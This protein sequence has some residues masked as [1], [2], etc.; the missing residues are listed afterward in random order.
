MRLDRLFHGRLYYGWIVAGVTFLSLLAAAGVRSMP[1]VLIVPLERDFGWTRATVSAA[2]SINLLLY[3]F[4]GPFAAALMDR[5]GVRRTMVLALA[6]LATGVGMTTVMRASWQLDVLWGVVVGIGTGAMAMTLG[7]YVATRWFAE[8]R[9]LVMGMLTASSATGQLIFLPLLASLVVLH[10][11][12][13]ATST[14]AVVALAMIPVV[15][16]FMRNDP[17]DIGLRP[18]GAT[19][20]ADADPSRSIRPPSS[21]PAAPEDLPASVQAAAEAER[22]VKPPNPAVAAVRALSDG[23]RV[24]DFW[25]LAG[26][27]FV[28][29]ASTQGLIGTHL[30]PASMEHGIPEVTAAGML[31]TI[32]VFDLVGTVCSG[33][34]TDRWDSRYLLC[35]YYALRGLSLLFLPYALGTSFAGMAAFAVFYGL[36]WVATVPPT[37]RLTADIFGRQRV[38]I[39]FGWI[40]ASHQVGSAIAAFGAGAARTSF[41]T[42]QGAFMAAGLLCLIASGL[43]MR[44]SPASRGLTPPLRPAEAGAA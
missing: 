40:F 10:G 22:P 23:M 30:I 5:L 7:A 9:G 42:Y 38:G 15:A 27:F 4:A 6:F 34:L 18:L 35:W 16:I 12:R 37:V 20:A 44:I 3:G 24:R 13:A 8:R 28:C 14:V 29:G 41:G 26:S 2:V 1:G 17:A 25:L 19:P 39:V 36:D 11:W 32:G 33:W 43:V 31:A 21:K